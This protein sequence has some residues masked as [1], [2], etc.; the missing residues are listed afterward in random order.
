MIRLTL[1]AGGMLLV[2]GPINPVR[3]DDPSFSLTLKDHHFT[4]TELSIPANV[5]V[6]LSV[7]NLEMAVLRPRYGRRNRSRE[8]F[9][10][11]GHAG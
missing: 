6:R 1:A 2:L 3:A 5:R 8:L 7:K 10:Q 4:P 11:H 9:L